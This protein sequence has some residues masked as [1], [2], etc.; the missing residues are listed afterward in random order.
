MKKILLLF[1]SIV[2]LLSSCSKDSE[3]VSFITTYCTFS[4]SGDQELFWP[5]NKPFVDPGCTASEGSTNVTVTSTSNLDIKKGGTYTINYKAVNSDGYAANTSRTVHVYD[6]TA[7]LTGYWTSNIVRNNAGTIAKRGPFSILLLGISPNEYLVA[8][9][10]GGWY[11]FGSNYG[12]AYAGPA[13]VKLN[14]DNTFTIESAT[15]TAF[16]APVE[17]SD[18][19]LYDPT[20]K[21][22]T[23][24]T[25]M[26]DTKTMLFNIT[27]TK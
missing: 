13:V 8:D 27:L 10:L 23:L 25:N 2:T 12:A 19:S 20:T 1:V 6:P 21:T 17:F 18:V 3:G 5:I 9:L 7:P 22:I 26:T 14:A 11:W 15:P 4:M 24:H 16:G